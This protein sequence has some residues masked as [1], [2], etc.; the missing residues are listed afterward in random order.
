MSTHTSGATKAIV[1]EGSAAD[2]RPRRRARSG[3]AG[4]GSR[5][6]FLVYGLL[7]AF[8]LGSAYPLW[9]SFVVGSGTNATRGEIG[10]AH[11]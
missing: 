11:V 3:V 2:T 10:R 4:I 8:V 5:P 9:W 1:T 6:G 7:A